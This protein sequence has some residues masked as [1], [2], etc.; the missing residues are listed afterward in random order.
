MVDKIKNIIIAIII[1]ALLGVMGVLLLPY[2]SRSKEKCLR[3]IRLYCDV[4]F[5]ILKKFYNINLFQQMAFC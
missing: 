5:W 3:V 2:A 1:Y 4:V